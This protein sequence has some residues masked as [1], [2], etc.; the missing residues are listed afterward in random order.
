LITK[1]KAIAAIGRPQRSTSRGAFTCDH[2]LGADATR[3]PSHRSTRILIGLALAIVALLA[4]FATPASAALKFNPAGEITGPSAGQPF[5]TLHSESVAVNDSNGH[6]LIAD[7]GTGLVY[8]FASASDTSPAVWDGS[9]SPAGSFG[10]SRIAVAADNA[11]GDVYVAD[12]TNAVIDKFT[13]AG[14][15]SCQ[16]TAAGSATASAS[17]CDSADPGAPDGSF[18]PAGL[19]SF[20]IAV[21]QATHDLYAIDA[22]H[23]V[24]DRFDSTGAYLSQVVLAPNVTPSSFADGIAV[25]PTNGH[26]FLSDSGPVLAYEFDASG[27]YVKT[28]TGA[29][30]PD[31]S[32][33]NGY[34]SLALDDSSGILFVTDTSHQVTDELD[35]SGTYLGQITGT[36]GGSFGGVSVD[37][38]SGDL[39]VSDGA[40]ETVKIFATGFETVTNPATA[41]GATTATLNGHLDPAGGS[42]VTDCHFAYVDD[43]HYNP[44]A[45]DPY[46]AGATA[47]CAEG[48]SFSAPA[49]VHADLTGLTGGTT[50]HF[51]LVAANA[52]GANPG[53]DRT[54]Q[55]LPPPS[56][57]F[58]AAQN[59]TPTDADLVAKINPNGFDTTCH[60]DWGTDTSYGN[61]AP[62]SPADLGSGT[63]DVTIST[64]LSGLTQDTTYHWRIVATNA[65][66]TVGAGVDHTFIY[67]TTGQGL[68]DNRA[69]E[70]VTPA[71]KNGAQFNTVGV[72]FPPDIS[73]DGE[74]VMAPTPQCLAQSDSCSVARQPNGVPYFFDR[75]AGGWVATE[76][77][78]AASQFPTSTA[79]VTSSD[80]DTALF[81]APSPPGGQEDFYAR[82]ADGTFVDIGPATPPSAGPQGTSPTAEA[83]RVMTADLSHLVWGGVD[84][85][86]QW[87]FDTFGSR[88][89]EYVGTGNTQPLL[90]GVSGGAGST[91]L[92]STCGTALG[93]AL[94][95]GGQ[96][97]GQTAGAMSAD[98]ATVYFTAAKCSSGSGA[99]AG[100]PVPA[101]ALYARIDQAQTTAISTRSPA[102][103][104][105]PD[106]QASAPGDAGYQ[107]TSADGSKVLFTSTQQLTDAASEDAAGGDSG[108]HCQDTTGA[109]GC[110]LYLYDFA[111][112]AGHNL[113]AVSAGAS[114]PRV[115]GLMALSPDGSH[116]YFVA[117]GVL[118]TD[119]NARGQT[120]SDGADNVYL[121]ARDGSNP[122]GQLA[123]IATLPES[124]SADW[125]PNGFA[126]S[127]RGGGGPNLTPDGRFLVFPSHAALTPDDTSASGA[128]QIFRYDAQTG[129]LIRISIGNDGFNDNGNRPAATP[130]AFG[131]CSENATLAPAT[132]FT[133][134][135]RTDQTMSDDGA[136]VFF[137]SPLAL[138]PHA[139]DDVRVGTDDSGKPAYAQNIYEWHDGHVFLISDG[140]DTGS[141]VE[142]SDVY[143]L[144]SSTS[145]HDVFFISSDRLVPQ[146]T[147]TQM[148]IYDA[149][150]GGGFPFTPPPEPCS[151]DSCKPPP[152]GTPPDQTPGSSSL[153]GPG[154]QGRNL[155]GTTA[156]HKKKCK[157]HHKLKHGK[158]V[159][160]KGRRK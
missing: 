62:C 124:D 110:N 138:T 141:Q 156:T 72:G 15:Y 109:N 73:A 111:N 69:Y 40:T 67:P 17:E 79:F 82:R 97:S 90:V 149:R 5:G 16:I 89:Y 3:A 14:T 13:S 87:P 153:S 139:L 150:V 55:T 86:G 145:G 33:G 117:K 113:I 120:A 39:Y 60:F 101:D 45:P 47:P 19:G 106:C 10:G 28:L 50:Y 102:D 42:D 125:S 56:I 38:A 104:T 48:N 112:P 36:P 143:L 44:A 160:K 127:L 96:G 70:Q 157:K 54:F 152:S 130:C 57:D 68:P 6:I 24:V 137:R 78:P 8:D 88:L 71:Q 12:S 4:V 123:F 116:V 121:F 140:R 108:H 128:S 49:D 158:C 115:Q 119:P 122:G 26:L 11:S 83:L 95:T 126:S 81:S 92:I 30:T 129:A 25:N 135:R 37:Q 75:T 22:G 133:E 85:G 132:R 91:D 155:G 31:G 77:A 66:G 144:G 107:A 114:E 18:S 52:D 1:A 41:V 151:G 99:N 93:D 59:L 65:N 154:N 84:A 76:T 98:G 142:L 136:Y 147:D 46:G 34:I 100:V 27:N 74:R 103:C 21:D 20:G 134:P 43:A 131:A 7:S 146:D 105:T 63:S 118:T 159:K 23:A 148:D 58:A 80:A 64:H 53:Q 51:R 9:T 35:S 94:I 32:F 29:D 61:T 2:S